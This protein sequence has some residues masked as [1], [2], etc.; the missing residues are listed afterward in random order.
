MSEQDLEAIQA[1][2]LGAVTGTYMTLGFVLLGILVLMLF[3]NMPKGGDTDKNIALKDT[4]GRLF[5][6]KKYLFGVIAQFFYNGAQIGVWSFTIRYVMQELNVLEK[7]ASNIYLIAI[8]CFCISRFIFTWLMKFFAPSRLM[9]WASWGALIATILVIFTSGMGW[10]PIIALI[11]TPLVMNII[12]IK[13]AF[14]V[15]IDAVFVY[16][17]LR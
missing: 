12:K 14:I 6:N 8:I 16:R 7:D 5:K 3:A 1:H 2:E 15:M 9:K 10:L 11:V 13:T 17:N 4:F